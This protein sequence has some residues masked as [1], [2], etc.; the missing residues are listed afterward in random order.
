M[1][2]TPPRL[3]SSHAYL[4]GRLGSQR[5]DL[6]RA[7]QQLALL[8]GIRPAIEAGEG[9]HFSIQVTLGDFNLTETFVT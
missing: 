2:L 5:L 1:P 7:C 4:S 6:A 8:V 3:H 9:E